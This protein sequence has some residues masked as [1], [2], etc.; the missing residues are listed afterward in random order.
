[1]L[2]VA[3][4]QTQYLLHFTPTKLYNNVFDSRTSPKIISTM[5]QLN[6]SQNVKTS[7]R[8]LFKGMINECLFSSTQSYFTLDVVKCHAFDSSTT[9]DDSNNADE[10]EEEDLRSEAGNFGNADGNG[11]D[12]GNGNHNGNDNDN[13]ER[14]EDPEFNDERLTGLEWWWW[15]KWQQTCQTSQTRDNEFDLWPV[16]RAVQ[17]VANGVKETLEPAVRA[18]VLGPIKKHVTMQG[19]LLLLVFGAFFVSCVQMFAGLA[20]VS[21]GVALAGLAGIVFAI[22]WQTLSSKDQSDDH[23]DN[24]EL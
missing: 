7:E 13:N 2:S 22:L 17:V 5:S 16:N 18:I 20:M 15:W 8:V 19:L 14:E 23:D 4:L 6:K 12:N 11:N 1:M 3:F 21:T 10:V 24:G 9:E